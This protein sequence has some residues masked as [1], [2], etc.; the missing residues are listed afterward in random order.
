MIE[1]LLND[2]RK[3]IENKEPISP[4]EW[5]DAADRLNILR[6]DYDDKLWQMGQELFKL[7][8]MYLE[9]GKMVGYSDTVMKS[10]ELYK[11]WGQLKSKLERITETVRLSKIR[12]KLAN[13][14]WQGQR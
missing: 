10:S 14:E 7:K 9:Q 11:N 12:S 5:L 13:N 2:I 1:E 4:I 3:K 8:A 6:S